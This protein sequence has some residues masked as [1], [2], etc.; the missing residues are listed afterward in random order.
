M[1]KAWQSPE[2]PEVTPWIERPY[3]RFRYR[4]YGIFCKREVSILHPTP[5]ILHPAPYTLHPAPYT[6]HPTLYSLKPL[7]ST[8]NPEP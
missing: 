3:F 2:D 1:E 4:N 7:L 6:L 5:Y 8:L